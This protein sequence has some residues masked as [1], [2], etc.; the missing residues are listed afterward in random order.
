MEKVEKQL[1]HITLQCLFVEDR[2]RRCD[3]CTYQ[4]AYLS[5]S[6]AIETVFIRFKG[7]KKK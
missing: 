3:T 2:K 7:E 4:N 1:K 6:H 5:I